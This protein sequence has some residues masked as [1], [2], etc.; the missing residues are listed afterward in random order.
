MAAAAAV[1]P[2]L[3][4]GPGD[5]PEGSEADAPERRRKAHGMLKLYY[6]LSEGEATGH[7]AGSD[8]LD[9]TDLNGAHFDPEVYLDKLRRECPLAQLMDSETDMVRQ[10][11]ALD[12]DMQTLVYENY[13][14]FI[15]ATDTIRKMKNDFRKMEDE[16]DRLATNMAVITNFSARISATLQDRH[17]RITKLAGVHALLRK[18][19]FLFEL[20]SRLTKCVELGAYG[21]A[22][23][24]QGRARAVLQ[25]YQH[26]P[27]F[28]AIQDDCQVITAR[29]AQQLRQRFREGC[30]GA[31]EQAE[32]VELLLA[33]GEPAEELCEEFLAHARGRLEEELSSLAELLA[34]VASSIL[35][36]IKASLASVHLFTAKEVSF[37]N[38]P[39]FRGEFCSQGVREGLI[40]GFIRSMCQT[41]Q[42]FCDSPGEKGGATPP[43]LLLLLSRLCLDYETATIS[44]ILTL[45]DEQFLVQDQ[46]PVTPVSTLCA[47]AR[48]TAR[49]LLTHY[50]K[51]QGLVISQMLRK[52][53]ETR[54]W[55][56]TLEPRNV[57]AVM[58]RVVED[59]TAIDV[60]VG[61]LYEEGVRKA[62]SSD[63]SKR[64]FSVYSS[65]RQQGRYAPSYTP[66]APMDT[67]LLSNIQKLF[68]ERIDVFSPVEFN[69]V[70]VLT[71][72]IKISLKTLLECVR[73]RTFGRFGLQQVQ[74]DCHFLQLYLW[75]F[76]AD[77]E[78]VHL[79][80]D[81]VVASAALRC[82]DPVPME[83]SVVEVIC[84]R[85]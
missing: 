1:G 77:E 10:I 84:E 25:Q 38:K 79:L 49:R 39:Y 68:S 26:L 59:T 74:V 24:Y 42:G 11:R 76:V 58:K 33:L 37:S 14:K 36:H 43:A 70:S 27:S 5:S 41:A 64:T 48:E 63:S 30:S 71:G 4:S 23:R 45:T 56:S 57:R 29:L 9:P 81:E 28:R 69:K 3:G 17:E 46:S 83:P 82:P 55:L 78:L 54:D 32:C 80:L 19:Q 65:S 50:V 40:V 34:N 21:Q 22:V 35:S 13:N 6:G 18:L 75:R 62:Q 53:V 8:P 67:N 15:S 60:Q 85:G 2:G 12:S 73:L 61:L 52:S 7:S 47:E 44:Y 16:M 51:V 72:I 20:P 31:P 66:S